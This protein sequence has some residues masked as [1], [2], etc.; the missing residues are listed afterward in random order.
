MLHIVSVCICSLKYPAFS[1]HAPYCP[2]WPDP[3]Y[4]IFHI[5][6]HNGTIFEEQRIIEHKIIEHKTIEH[7]IIENK[8]I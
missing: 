6:S 2:L 8:I 4:N 7:K 1:A 3:L 5:L